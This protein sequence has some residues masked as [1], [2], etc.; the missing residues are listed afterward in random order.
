MHFCISVHQAHRKFLGF[1]GGGEEDVTLLIQSPA[2][3]VVELFQ[4]IDKVFCGN[5]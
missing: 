5:D 3:H 2:V 1:W 4:A